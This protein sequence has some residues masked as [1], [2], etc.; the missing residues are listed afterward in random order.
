MN[1]CCMDRSSTAVDSS[2][3]V[4]LQLRLYEFEIPPPLSKQLVMGPGLL[5]T[6]VLDNMDNI[7]VPDGA[8]PMS[9]CDGCS[10]DNDQLSEPDRNWEAYRPLLA[11]SNAIWT[12]FSDSASKAL[13]ASARRAISASAIESKDCL[14]IQQQDLRVPNQRSSDTQPLSLTTAQVDTFHSDRSIN[15]L[16]QA[17]D[18]VPDAGQ[19]RE[20]SIF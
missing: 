19:A 3:F 10:V 20:V 5:H 4:N 9:D 8:E 16:F 2:F 11:L 7:C 1:K 12:A 13:V 17:S 18:K 15:S 6:A 14:T